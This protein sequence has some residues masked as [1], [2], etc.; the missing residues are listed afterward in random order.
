MWR[1]YLYSTKCIVFTDH[2]NLKH[3]LDQKELNMRQC[4]WLELLSD[5]DYKIRY[6]LRKANMVAD[7]LSQKERIKPLRVQALVMTMGLNLLVKILNAQVEARKEENYG[8]EDLGGMIKNLEPPLYGRKCRSSV[9][10]AKVRDAQPAGPKIIHET[11]EKIIKI[12]KR[13]QAARDRQK[14]YADRRCK[15]LEFQAGE[16]VML[17]VSVLGLKDFMMILELLL[18]RIKRLHDDLRVTT[19]QII[20]NGNAPIVTNTVD[21]K[22][23]VIPPTSVEEKAQRR[24]ELKARSTL[25]MA[26]PNKHQL[27]FNSYKVQAIENKFGVIPQEDINQKF[28][29][30]LSQEW[31]M[32][33]IVWRNKPEIETLSLDDLFNNLKAYESKVNEEID[34]RWN[35]A[36][37][38]MRERRFLK[39]TGRKLDMDNKERIGFDKSKVE[40][41]NCHKRG[42]FAKEFRTPRNQ[43]SRN[44]EPT[45]RTVPVEETI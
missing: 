33:T 2:K 7:A 16:Q 32:N 43:D 20:E 36:M 24:A 3:I 22:E 18:L 4:R 6:H 42:H 41:F 28:L 1:H 15:P 21:G 39:N 23:T 44:T 5:Y 34:L 38:T 35:I 9:C 25:L 45:R 17:K 27:N 31:T 29:R 10:W 37:L 26:L 8:T 19:A 13:I 11:T 14:S 30:N 40:Y 12:K